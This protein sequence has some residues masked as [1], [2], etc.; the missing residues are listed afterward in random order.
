MTTFYD[1]RSVRIT[2]ET[3][4]VRGHDY[5]LSGLSRVWSE[6][7]ARRWGA[8]AR[9]AGLAAGLVAPLVAAVL[10][11]IVA[12]RLDLT[13]TGT[14][15]LV[16]GS[17][18]VGLATVPLADLLFDRLEESYARGTRDLQLWAEFRGRPVLLLH[19]RDAL[20]FGRILRALRRALESDLPR[21]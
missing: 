12:F 6:R 9:R 3:I 15:A 17:V 2:S 19:T 1:D 4:R 16:G 18:V 13:N 11:V 21:A 10:G 20:H 14:V 5:P 8:L 7:G